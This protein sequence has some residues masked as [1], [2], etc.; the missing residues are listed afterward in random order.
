LQQVNFPPQTSYDDGVV[1]V[2]VMAASFLAPESFNLDVDLMQAHQ[3]APSGPTDPNGSDYIGVLK[4]MVEPSASLGGQLAPGLSAPVAGIIPRGIADSGTVHGPDI[5]IGGARA[6]LVGEPGFAGNREGSASAG[7][8][9]RDVAMAG[10]EAEPTA[11][12][13]GT[14]GSAPTPVTTPSPKASGSMSPTV[15]PAATLTPAATGTSAT[16]TPRTSTTVAVATPT[17]PKR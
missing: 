11:A 9:E 12:E 4:L 2:S 7:S 14:P 13:T 3:L 8:P 16:P 17:A 1:N 10:G 15:R 5:P 6:G